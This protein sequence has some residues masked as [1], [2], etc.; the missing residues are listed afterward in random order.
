ML[1]DV[2]DW[3]LIVLTLAWW[4]FT[5]IYG[6]RSRWWSNEVGRVLFPEKLLM[7]LVL[8]QVSWS[9]W[10]E[11]G[12]PGRDP[13]RIVLYGLGALSLMWMTVV[14]VSIQRRERKAGGD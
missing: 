5:L 12:Y 1:R 13:V 4:V 2:G 10:T 6:F 8:S 7:C 9:T 11:S 3:L 14:L